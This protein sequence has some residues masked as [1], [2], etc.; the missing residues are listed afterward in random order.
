MA[1]WADVRRMALALAASEERSSRGGLA[2]WGVRDKMFAWERPLRP[3][4]A[5]ELGGWPTSTSR[6]GRTR[7]ASESGSR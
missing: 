7:A 2:S 3:K 6:R 1:D 4:E 5:L